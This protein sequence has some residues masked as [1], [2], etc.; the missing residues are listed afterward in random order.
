MVKRAADATMVT[1]TLPA[2]P[3]KR[4]FV[5]CEEERVKLPADSTPVLLH[6]L[7]GFFV[8][9]APPSMPATRGTK[10]I[11]SVADGS[12]PLA[13]LA[14]P[15]VPEVVVL[16]AG[17]VAV[18][19]FGQQGFFVPEGLADPPSPAPPLNGAHGRKRDFTVASG[20]WEDDA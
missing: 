14:Y 3:A 2:P 13:K 6:G 5:A 16:P 15:A 7:R 20:M 9:E 19:L 10:R 18:V 4:P 8:P 12:A 11:F 1:V 17:A